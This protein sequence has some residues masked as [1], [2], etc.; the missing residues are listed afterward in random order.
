VNILHKTV[1][2]ALLDG[3]KAEEGVKSM[4]LSIN[5]GGVVCNRMIA[6]A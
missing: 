1:I 6:Y 5:H 3:S 4:Q 2:G